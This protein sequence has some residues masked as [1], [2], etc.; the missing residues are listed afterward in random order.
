ML[1][2]NSLL[3]LFNKNVSVEIENLKDAE[4]KARDEKRYQ[5]AFSYENQK[6]KLFQMGIV[7]ALAKYNVIPGYGFPIDVVP[8]KVYDR[9]KKDFNKSLDLGR[10]LA[11]ALSE[12]AP[13]SEIIVDKNKYTSRYIIQP[14]EGSL[15]KFFYYKCLEK[16]CEKIQ[17]SNIKEDFVK[18]DVCR[19][20]TEEL[21][22]IVPNLGF[23]T[24]EKNKESTILKPRKTYSSEISYLGSMENYQADLNINDFL[25]IQQTSDDKLL[26]VNEN[27][28]FSCSKCG[29]SVLDKKKKDLIHFDQKHNTF[30]GNECS[31]TKLEQ[32]KLGHIII[33]DVIKM[34]I[35]SLMDF[36]TAFSTINAISNGITSYLQIDAN[37]INGILVKDSIDRYAFVFYD[38]TY[39]GAG[40]VKQLTD[41]NG[42]KSV[43]EKALVSVNSDCCNEEVSCTNCLRNYKNS[44][45]HKNLK[46]KNAKERIKEIL[47]KFNN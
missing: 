7:E 4:D 26:I 34:K 35:D 9:I 31:N 33:T 42:L 43:L 27:P 23:I 41:R 24:D 45:Y 16:K 30:R 40:N 15:P 25:F 3:N 37:D 19:S 46:R 38:T 10:D 11:V 21:S 47:I 44:K 1:D 8:L 29:Y 32:I 5:D 18:C 14:K 39:G 2:D 6:K 22:F 28:F 36:D 12:Y 20:E 17:I 13:D